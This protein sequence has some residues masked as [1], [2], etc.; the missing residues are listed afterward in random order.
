MDAEAPLLWRVAACDE[1]DGAELVSMT[2]LEDDE[3]AS[4][5]GVEQWDDM[6]IKTAGV[7]RCVGRR[8]L[9]GSRRRR[10]DT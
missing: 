6:T 4:D 2:V 9:W 5:C 8:R 7:D 1:E 10:R 3:D